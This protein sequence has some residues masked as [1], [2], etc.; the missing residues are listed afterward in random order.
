MKKYV[1]FVLVL[2]LGMMAAC[3]GQASTPTPAPPVVQ[4]VVMPQTVVVTSA[5]S[6]TEPD[7]GVPATPSRRRW[8]RRRTRR[9]PA[10]RRW[11]RINSAPFATR[12]STSSSSCKRTARSTSILALTR[13]RTAFRC[14]MACR[15]SDQRP[16]NEAMYQA[17]PQPRRRQFR[18]T[19]RGCLRNRRYRR[20]ENGRLR[21][22]IPCGIERLQGQEPGYPGLRPG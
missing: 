15:Q 21:R 11:G 22:S 19:P 2:T 4:T 5:P 12:S 6:A 14:R 9:R 18:G 8:A 17:V 3:S 7:G 20:R 13:V 16:P 1:L 10:P